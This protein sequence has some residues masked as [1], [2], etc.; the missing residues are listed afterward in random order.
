MP[1]GGAAR[2]AGVD[3]TLRAEYPD[4][5]QRREQQYRLEQMLQQRGRQQQQ[6]ST[7]QELSESEED[8]DGGLGSP[9][10]RRGVR[11][12]DALLERAAREQ[13]QYRAAIHLNSK[14]ALP[15]SRLLR[16]AQ[17]ASN[18]CPWPR[19]LT[20][21]T[22]HRQLARGLSASA[23][24]N[25]YTSLTTLSLEH[26]LINRLENLELPALRSLLLHHNRLARLEAAW[27]RGAPAGRTASLPASPLT[28]PPAS[29]SGRAVS[30]RLASA[31][32]PRSRL[33]GPCPPQACRGCCCSTSASTGSPA[34]KA[35][36]WAA[37]PP[38]PAQ[39]PTPT[40]PSDAALPLIRC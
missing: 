20:L 36:R 4:T 9:T 14:L 22:A 19:L 39:G 11:M 29:A 34:S 26:N 18:R 7:P 15:M 8:E 5:W 32:A 21:A 6:L 30:S 35:S 23:A 2:D 28:P 12:S 38:R 37:A 31:W 13:G 24:L 17:Q 40:R 33:R 16:W 27:L 25:R 3:A 10:R 1:A